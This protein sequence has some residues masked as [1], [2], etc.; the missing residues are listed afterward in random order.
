MNIQY[1]EKTKVFHLSTDKI[2]YI[3]GIV[4]DGYLAHLYY[5]SKIEL[6]DGE[7]SLN[8]RERTS[9]S[10]TPIPDDTSFSF[11]HL[12]QEYPGFGNSDFREPAFA[13]SDNNGDH[14]LDLKYD[15]HIIYNRKKELEGLPSSFSKANESMTL[16][17]TLIDEITNLNVILIYTIFASQSV[18][19]RSVKYHNQGEHN[20][21]LSKV[22]SMSLDFSTSDFELIHLHGGWGKERNI[23]RRQLSHGIFS[24]ESKRGVSSHQHSPFIG[25]LGENC[26]EQRGEVYGFSLIYSGS[27]KAQI[28]VDQFE[29]T[30]LMLGI[31]DFNFCWQLQVQATFQSPECVLVYSNQGLNGMSQQFHKFVSKHIITSQFK[32]KL[33]PIVINNWEATYF[34]FTSNKLIEIAKVAKDL[35]IE[36]FV[37]DDGWFGKRDND[38]CSLGDWTP[39]LHKIPEGLNKLSEEIN[40]IGLGFGLWVEPE[41]VSPNSDLFRNHPEWC[42]QI[43]GRAKT[44]ARHQL[45][46]DLSQLDVQA[47]IINFMDKLLTENNIN[48]IK[49]DMNRPLTEMSSIALKTNQKGEFQHRYVLGL[50]RV[51]AEIVGRH[52]NV[53]F[54]SCSGGGGRFDLGMFYYMPQAW[55]SDNSDA[56]ERLKIQYSTSLVYPPIL[57][58]AQVSAAPNHQVGRFTSLKMRGDVASFG[59]FGYSLDLTKLRA[60]ELTEIRQQVINYKANRQL[61]SFGNFYRIQSPFQGNSCSWIVVADN[62]KIAILAYY[63]IL[64]KPNAEIAYAKFKYLDPNFIYFVK[65]INKSFTGSYLMNVGLLV[66]ELKGDFESFIYTIEVIGE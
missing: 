46:L 64:N 26:T 4:N 5:G 16:E 15:S 27:F 61:I 57:M 30:R 53:L 9:F 65:E 41:M 34:D 31:N 54:E 21:S 32:N 10:P 29:T 3:I 49:W 36:Q 6:I 24:V 8:L 7:F 1:Y 66:P 56:V 50:Y 63:Q 12:P 14:V 62:K 37:L 47:Y 48:Y 13:V 17:V 20:I 43:E 18:L 28:E 39:D 45:V 23:E 33:R 19:T 22:S 51:L 11:D 58:G 40:D 38:T 60:D 59:N 52:P 55:T 35:G 42:V 25:L 44:Q 2:S